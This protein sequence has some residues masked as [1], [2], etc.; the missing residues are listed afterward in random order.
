MQLALDPAQATAFVLASVRLL[1]FL[2]IAPP[3]ATLNVPLPAWP[4]RIVV[5]AVHVE[6]LPM[7]VAVPTEPTL[8]AMIA[9]LGVVRV[10]PACKVRFP[11][12]ELPT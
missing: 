1:A 2:M 9:E 12:P 8:A 3:F 5:L 7:T 11:V 4:M 10:E 6:P